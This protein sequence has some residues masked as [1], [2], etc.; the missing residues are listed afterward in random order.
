M[1]VPKRRALKQ[2]GGVANTG[3]DRHRPGAQGPPSRLYMVFRGEYSVA[4]P[5]TAPVADHIDDP[6]IHPLITGA[7][8]DKA[9]RKSD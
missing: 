9:I 2:T 1:K 8:A 3:D 5:F 7:H 6:A 4:H